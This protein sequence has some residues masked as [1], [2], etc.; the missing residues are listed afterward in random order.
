MVAYGNCM[1]AGWRCG[2]RRLALGLWLPP[3][4]AMCLR[5][6]HLAVW[7]RVLRCVMVLVGVVRVKGASRPCGLETSFDP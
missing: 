1:A 6:L 2:C 7:L 4:C 5:R 3:A